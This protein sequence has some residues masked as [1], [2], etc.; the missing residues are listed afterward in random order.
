VQQWLRLGRGH[1]HRHRLLLAVTH[2]PHW[3]QETVKTLP[4]GP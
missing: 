2:S 1:S 4:N 3:S